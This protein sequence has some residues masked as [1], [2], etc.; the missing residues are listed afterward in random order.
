LMP[1]SMGSN[2]ILR[3]RNPTLLH[4]IIKMLPPLLIVSTTIA[5]KT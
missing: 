3:Q 5:Q 2:S 1:Q 4:H